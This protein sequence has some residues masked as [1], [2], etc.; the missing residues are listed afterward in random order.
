MKRLRSRSRRRPVALLTALASC[1]SLLGLAAAQPVAASGTEPSQEANLGVQQ[2]LFRSGTAGYG[3]FRIPTLTTTKNGT[4]LAFAEA[5]TSPSCADRGPIDIVMRRSTNEGRTWSPIRAVLSGRAS[6]SGPAQVRGN[7]SPVA[8][9][10][11]DKK[12]AVFLFSNSEPAVPGGTRMSWVR[13]SDDDGVTFQAPTAVPRLTGGKGWFG[14]GPSHGIQIRKKGHPHQGRLVVGAYESVNGDDQRVGLLYSDD[15]GATWNSGLT[16]DSFRRAGEVP[17]VPTQ[18]D[19]AR[20]DWGP[21]SPVARPG[22]PVVAELAD[23]SVHV[24]ARSPYDVRVNTT[25]PAAYE[26]RH[27]MHVTATEAVDPADGKTKAKVP[28]PGFTRGWVGPD[29]QVSVLAPR[30]TYRTTPG[31]L[32]LMSAPA[33]PDDR[34]EMR[35]RYSLDQGTTWKDAPGG[36]VGKVLGD[37]AGY[38]DMAELSAG[39]IGMVYESGT[40]FSAQHIYFNRFTVDQLRLP[41]A[42]TFAARGS[43]LPQQAP[44]AGRTTPDT[45]AEANDA[46]LGDGTAPG[47]G[48]AFG[49]RTFGHGLRFNGGAGGTKGSADLPWTASLNGGHGEH[50]VL[51]VLHIHLD[52]RLP[53]AGPHVGI[54]RRRPEAAGVGPGAAAGE[55][56]HGARG[57]REG[58]CDAD[59]PRAA[60]EAGHAGLRRRCLAPS[61]AH[62]K[63]RR[64]HARRRRAPP[65][66]TSFDVGRLAPWRKDDVQGIR[67]GDKL[68]TGDAGADAN[69][70]FTGT[71]DEFRVYREALAETQWPA[72]RGAEPEKVAPGSL[73][74]HL[75]FEIVDTAGSASLTNVRIQDDVSGRCADGTLLGTGSPERAQV[76]GR[77]GGAALAVSP[78]LPGVEA[79]YVPAVDNGAGDFTFAL[80]FRY[81]SV[82]NAGGAALLSAYG[83]AT[84]K[85]SLSVGAR[86]STN[87]L[88]AHA[89]TTSASATIGLEDTKT[90][91]AFGDNTWHLLTLARAGG[92]LTMRVDAGAPATATGLTG[93]FTDTVTAPEGVRVGSKPDGTEVLT[94]KFDDVRFYRRALSDTERAGLLTAAK[95]GW[96]P[97]LHPAPALW[98]TMDGGHTEQHLVMGPPSI[99]PRAAP[100]TPRRSATTPSCAAAPPSRTRTAGSAAASASTGRTTP[101]SCPTGRR[102]RWATATS[103]WRPGS[104]AGRPRT[105]NP[106]WSGVRGRNH[107]TPVVGP[108]QAGAERHRRPR[109]DGP[110]DHQPGGRGPRPHRVRRRHLAARGPAPRRREAHAV[111]R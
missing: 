109:P 59:R 53:P 23:G 12:G 27:R 45:T 28:A 44:A 99:P 62:P 6:A 5:R 84:G 105:T 18:P 78:A 58:R 38:S 104:A 55:P 10:I 4:L 29:V 17:G 56:G 101:S 79:P 69:D 66:V 107:R 34:Q 72:L 9:V 68:D 89:A 85:P 37:R 36:Q 8:D 25:L 24:S 43:T 77:V 51:P 40:S 15:R 110:G 30:R 26:A 106:C 111:G 86:P 74:A 20:P 91:R 16:E 63:G 57:G 11:E 42:G 87:R 50:D 92:T 97:P 81:D 2:V 98:W 100:P 73:K 14:T 32:L 39:D 93:S 49:T 83:S 75:P 46:Y 103:P 41:E 61:G 96:S 94:G 52:A 48:G 35:L 33:H 22:E 3:C 7:P 76:P 65:A 71:I 90:G 13:R 67:L 80:W 108:C 60:R 19:P 31:D 64:D 82:R 70:G 88:T 1:A 54:R 47:P 102:R 21:E 95:G